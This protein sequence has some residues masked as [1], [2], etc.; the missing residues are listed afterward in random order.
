M[1]TTVALEQ[2]RELV[3][4]GWSQGVAARTSSGVECYIHSDSAAQFDASGALMRV[5]WPW[6]D[7]DDEHLWNIFQECSDLLVQT[8]RELYG[9][10][11][12][13]HPPWQI[14]TDWNDEPARTKEEVIDL[15]NRTL[16]LARAAA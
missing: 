1:E 9:W 15:F 11:M 13:E 10:D 8:I 4:A 3:R 7:E 5:T 12:S 16:V 6:D 14:L 2:A